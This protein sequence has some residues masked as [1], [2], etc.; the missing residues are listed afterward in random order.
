MP[1]VAVTWLLNEAFTTP[2]VVAGQGSESAGLMVNAQLVAEPPSE[3]VTLM[4]KVPLTV[5]VPV[6][7]PV[8]LFSDKPAGRAPTTE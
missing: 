1:P 4:L 6:M 2:V 5:G 7:A 8:E 3:S